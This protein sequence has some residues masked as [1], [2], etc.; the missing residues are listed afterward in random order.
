MA[1]L[2]SAS[3]NGP[4]PYPGEPSVTPTNINACTSCCRILLVLAR[5]VLPGG[6][7]QISEPEWLGWPSKH[8]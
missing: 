2:M 7:A 6:V 8:S 4:C 1:D 5:F 3:P